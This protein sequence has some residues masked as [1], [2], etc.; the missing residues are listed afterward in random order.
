M[1]FSEET[2]VGKRIECNWACTHEGRE[3]TL[4]DNCIFGIGS[5]VRVAKDLPED[6]RHF[7]SPNKVGTVIGR[8]LVTDFGICDHGYY[9][10]Y[11]LHLDG[12]G[13]SAWYPENTL[14]IC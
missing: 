12:I 4:E 5:R 13:C 11:K 9:A 6:M 7:Q 1:E 14:N 10:Q 2:E 8:D 3:K